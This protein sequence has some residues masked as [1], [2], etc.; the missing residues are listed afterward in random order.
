MGTTQTIFLSSTYSDLTD[1]RAKAIDVITSLKQLYEGMEYFGAD[2]RTPL[3]VMLDKLSYCQI[4]V[5]IIGM[6]YGSVDK[7]SNKSYTQLEYERAM[8]LKLPCLIYIIDEENA[9]IAPK[10][11]E[12]GATADLL[13]AFK[14][15]LKSAHVVKSFDSVDALGEALQ[16]D[17]PKVIERLKRQALEQKK[18]EA[19]ATAEAEKREVDWATEYKNIEKAL[20]RPVKYHGK[21][22]VLKLKVLEELNGWRLKSKL[23]NAFGF[24]D[25][26]TSSLDVLILPPQDMKSVVNETT[27]TVGLYI[28]GDLAEW[29]IERRC[30]PEMILEAKVKFLCVSVSGI[31]RDGTEEVIVALEMINGISASVEF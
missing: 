11:V 2:E 21:E 8:E 7:A 5:G 14:N 4:Y 29:L 30:R 26:D 1:Y 24:V 20:L 17:I 16:H 10:D 23:V 12:R 6:R 22:F 31:T 19:K 13:D 28:P 9:R 25:G 18:E 15:Q 27:R 3:D